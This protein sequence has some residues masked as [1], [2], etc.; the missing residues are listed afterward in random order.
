MEN[1]TVPPVLSPV[2]YAGFWLRFVAFIIDSIVIGIIKWILISPVLVFFGISTLNNMDCTNDFETIKSIT[3]FIGTMLIS[4]L[5]IVV[6][7]WLYYALLESSPH[8]AT[9]GKLA[10][11]IK[12]TDESGNR[13]TLLRASGRHFAKIIS[14]M[15]LMIGFIMAGFT[16]KKQALHDMIANCLVI[17]K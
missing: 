1:Q 10:V 8:Q 3:L 7:T 9:I 6:L 5:V 16:E 2:K 12:V 11:G 14:A 17:K 15:I 4:G 13:V